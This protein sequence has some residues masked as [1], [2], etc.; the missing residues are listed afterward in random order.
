MYIHIIVK[1]SMLYVWMQDTQYM[2]Y[3]QYVHY[4]QYIQY[5]QYMRVY[6]RMYY[7]TN[8]VDMLIS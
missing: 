1:W 3:T 5:T 6:V 7:S 8:W 2:Q 4:T